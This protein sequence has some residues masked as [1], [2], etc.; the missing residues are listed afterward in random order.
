KEKLKFD[1]S[2]TVVCPSC[3]GDVCVGTAGPVGLAQHEG[4]GPCH[5]A[6]AKKNQEKKTRTLFAIGLKKARDVLAVQ[7]RHARLDRYRI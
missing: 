7:C 4:K 5:K 3:G 1:D 2:T 6:Q